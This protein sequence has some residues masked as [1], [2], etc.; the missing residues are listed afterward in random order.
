MNVGID[1][2]STIYYAMRLSTYNIGIEIQLVE[3]D[4]NWAEH[5]SHRPWP[6]TNLIALYRRDSSQTSREYTHNLLIISSITNYIVKKRIMLTWHKKF[7]GLSNERI[8]WSNSLMRLSHFT[9]RW[10]NGWPFFSTITFTKTDTC[11]QLTVMNNVIWL[12]FFFLTSV[13]FYRHI[14]IIYLYYFIICICTNAAF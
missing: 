1:S 5:S 6:K 4:E 2:V 10:P 3:V 11:K 12:L 14:N 8:N 7:N 9:E 13:Q